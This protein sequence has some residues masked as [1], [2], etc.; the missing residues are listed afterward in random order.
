IRDRRQ[1]VQHLVDAA[2]EASRAFKT[3]RQATLEL[4]RDEAR[5]F[6][7]RQLDI[8]TDE[9]LA[10]VYEGLRDELAEVPLPT[11]EGI[12]TTR[13]MLLGRSPELADFNPL[14]MWDLSF[15][16]QALERRT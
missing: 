1:D 13:R 6:I 10:H 15:G 2:F 4:I 8:S 16:L 9:R 12:S 5:K 11:A 7:G 14:T 3:D